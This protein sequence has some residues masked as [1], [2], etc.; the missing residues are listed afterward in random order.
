MELSQMHYFLHV[1]ATQHITQSAEQLHI[2]QPALSQSIKRL[3]EDLGV[4]L[5]SSKGRGIVLTPCGQY[6]RERLTPILTELDNLPERLQEIENTDRHTLRLCVL[7]ASSLVAEVVIAYKQLHEHINFRFS[8]AEDREDSD[9][10]I[11]TDA[12]YRQPDPNDCYHFV[13]TEKI[14]LAVP[15]IEKYRGKKNIAL[16]EVAGEDFISLIGSRQLRA[17]CDKFCQQAK[18]TPN[19]SFESDNPAVVRNMIASNMGVGF[20]PACSWG[21]TNEEH[22]KLLDITEP[23]CHRDIRISLRQRRD[24]PLVTDFYAFLTEQISRRL[25]SG[26]NA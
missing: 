7:A 12:L 11:T 10:V 23:D 21:D 1:A 6:L 20:W 14:Y 16:A 26:K 8:Q 15:D 24:N 25:A 22:V 19:I 2:A 13:C 3:E 17:I 18:F 9:I 4:R 5:F